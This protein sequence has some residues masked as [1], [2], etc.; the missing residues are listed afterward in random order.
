[1]NF[2]DFDEYQKACVKS[3]VYPNKNMNFVIPTLGIVGEAG[4]VADKIKKVLRDDKGKFTTKSKTEISKEI[5]D[6]LWY[7]SM[8]CTE[9][10]LKLSDVI[11][12]NIDKITYRTKENKIH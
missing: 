8:L 2:K 5:G 6:T 4:E 3:A 11:K 12:M 7:I 9:L 10:N 1:M